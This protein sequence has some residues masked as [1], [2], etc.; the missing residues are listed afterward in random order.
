MA[1]GLLG[2]VVG[3]LNPKTRRSSGYAFLLLLAGLAPLA[4]TRHRDLIGVALTPGL[5]FLLPNLPT[6]RSVRS[7]RIVF[8]ALAVACVCI[9]GAGLLHYRA[10]WP[11]HVDLPEDNFPK[12]GAEFLNRVEIGSRMFNSYDYGGYLV[13]KLRK[14]RLDFID[15]RYFVFGEAVYRDYLEARDGGGRA[16][17]L[18]RRYDVDLLVI[19]Y[20]QPDG[21][22][23][24]ATRVREWPD[25]A[26]VFW[27]DATLIYMRRDRA[28]AQWLAGQE[29]RRVD[30]TL[31]PA[32]K[33]PG[34][35][36]EHFEEMVRE[37]R[38]AHADAPLAA[39]PQLVEA[40]AFEYNHRPQEAVQL[41]REVLRTQPA[42]RPAR[43]ALQRLEPG[44][45]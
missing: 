33:D 22:Q 24:L 32:M 28:P 23:A 1:L 12:A 39:R 34:Y 37:A 25:W 18:L 17:A 42:N 35:W 11:P 8:P 43:E 26:L 19:R 29:Y 41:Y 31:P 21:Y 14:Q 36:T 6:R 3:V 20:P 5:A 7:L 13:D 40:L 45:R 44:A 38:R 9:P 2:A 27:D 16:E 10:V 30:P 15:G 4:A